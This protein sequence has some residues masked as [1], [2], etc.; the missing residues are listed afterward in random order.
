VAGRSPEWVQTIARHNPVDWAVVPAR[1]GLA[2]G[3]DRA[4]GAYQRSL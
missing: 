3:I 1:E 4:F 2:S